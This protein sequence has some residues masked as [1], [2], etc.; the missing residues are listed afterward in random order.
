MSDTDVFILQAASRSSAGTGVETKSFARMDPITL[1]HRVCDGSRDAMEELVTQRLIMPHEG[2][3]VTMLEWIS[4]RVDHQGPGWAGSDLLLESA[5]DQLM[6]RFTRMPEEPD[7]GTDCRNYYRGFLDNLPGE[8]VEVNGLKSLHHHDELLRR[9]M[10]YLRRHWRLCLKEAWRREQKWIIAHD[11]DNGTEWIRLYVPACIPAAERDHWLKRNIGP[12]NANNKAVIQSRI[13]AWLDQELRDREQQ[14]RSDVACA[15]FGAELSP[16]VLEH[17]W[18]H[19]GLAHTVAR[20]KAATPG[21]LRR[22][23]AA[24]GAVRIQ[25]L[26][27]RI[28]H[29]VS[30]GCY[31]PSTVARDFDLHKSVLTRFAASNWHPC[32]DGPVPD[33]WLNTAQ[34]LASQP[35]FRA[36]LEEAGLDHLVRSLAGPRAEDDGHQYEGAV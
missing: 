24:L 18:S 13:D 29:D 22:S 17:G 26:V 30:A 21:R 6:D 27:T 9:F 8:L 23:I 15:P 35:R 12:I 16:Y 20:E 2:R 1:I 33:L 31:H 34:V 32:K 10:G 25:Q 3:R 4:S 19:D 11:Y 5:R 28:F 7:G 36:A 14:L